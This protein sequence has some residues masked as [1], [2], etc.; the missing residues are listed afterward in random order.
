[1]KSGIHWLQA[2]EAYVTDRFENG[3]ALAYHNLQH[4]REVVEASR[5]IGAKEHL[6]EDQLLSLELAAWFHDV[7]Y[8]EQR[9]EHEDKSAAIFREFAEK[10]EGIPIVEDVVRLIRV[11][12]MPQKPLQP[13]EMVICD[14]DLYHLSTALFKKKSDQLLEEMNGTEAEDNMPWHDWLCKNQEFFEDHHYFTQY[15]QTVLEPRKRENLKQIKSMIKDA[16]KG[17]K[18]VKKLEK[19]V[20]DLKNKVQEAKEIKPDRGIETMFRLTSRNHLAL[21]AM[22][23][24]K[25]NIMISINSIILSI[26]VS[27]LLRKL[28]ESPHLTIPTL[29]LTVVCLLTIV[30]AILA[31]RPNVS[32][33]TFTKYD[34]INK[35]TNLLFFGNFHGVKLED[36]EWGMK[37]MMKDA[38]YLYSSLIRD[39]Y[40]LGAVL[41]KKYRL[42]RISYTIFM[43]GFVVAVISFVLAFALHQPSL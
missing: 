13:D 36:Y 12:K 5:L 2:A 16:S 15:G 4:T 34:I 14:A 9:E 17:D 18:K 30:F 37:E 26:V 43:F 20:Q 28:E 32:S 38:D 6:Q 39:I 10:Q 23:D 27:V 31:T 1:M 24:N 35:R 22:A 11:T 33:G 8:L 41:G 29:I 3:P 7:G 25:A 42:L 40:F 21:S 19:K